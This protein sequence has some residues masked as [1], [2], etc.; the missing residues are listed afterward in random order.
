VDK[1]E[2]RVASQFRTRQDY[3]RKP[4][5]E[6]TAGEAKGSGHLGGG[7]LFFSLRALHRGDRPPSIRT[8]S[9]DQSPQTQSLKGPASAQK[10]M[11]A[12]RNRYLYYQQKTKEG[13]GV[14]N[15]SASIG[16]Q[17]GGGERPHWL[18]SNGGMDRRDREGNTKGGEEKRGR[19]GSKTVAI[20]AKNTRTRKRRGS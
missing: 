4:C 9:R 12:L 5:P 3:Q 8:Q 17:K 11:A 20:H 18:L 19:S 10:R 7:Q 13:E 14:S 2:A 6:K 15:W 1:S 16:T